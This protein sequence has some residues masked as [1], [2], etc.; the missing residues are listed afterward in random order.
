VK[1]T[2][3][4]RQPADAGFTLLELLVA[5]TL[6]ALI[7]AAVPGIVRTAGRSIQIAAEL[8]RSHADVSALDTIADKLSE[9]R[10]LMVRQDDGSRHIQFWGTEDAVRFIAPGFVGDRPGL[11]VY[12][13]GLVPNRAGQLVL[14]VTRSPL[15]LGEAE[16]VSAGG[17]IR[18]PMPSTHRL[19]FRY[20]GAQDDD[21]T[22]VWSDRWERTNGLPQMVEITIGS[23]WAWSQ[24]LRTVIVPLRLYQ[25]P[26][27]TP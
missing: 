1:R 6:L 3:V 8:T 26:F 9:A 19:A 16:G 5:L 23:G 14:A 15:A 22:P 18:L 11:L 27:K 12:E 4:Q 13:V 21:L 25:I 20:F 10:A 24:K 2:V 7:A 17:D